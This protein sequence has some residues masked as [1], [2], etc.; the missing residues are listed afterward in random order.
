MRKRILRLGVVPAVLL[1]LIAPPSVLSQSGSRS[2][3]LARIDDS[4]EAT[5][6]R[7]HVIGMSIG[8]KKNGEVIVAKG[9]GYA[10]LENDV[11][12]TEHTVYRIGSITK[13]F[14]AA[15]IMKLVEAGMLSLDD[16]LT[17][18][19]P[20]YSTAGH[21]IT[22]DRLLNHTSGIKGYT[23]MEA[24]GE[25]M[26]EDLSQEELIALF[27]A[28][29]FEFA[30]GEKYQYNN[31]AYYLLG[32]IIEKVTGQ[33]Y[34]EYLHENIWE[35]LGMLESHYLDNSPIVRNRAEGYEFRRGR[36]VNDDPLSM[37][38]PYS[39]GSLGSSVSDL[40][41]WQAA[42]QGNRVISEG[43]YER[44]I[45]PG[46]L[47]GGKKLTYGYG[48]GI[49]AMEGHRKISHGGGING[50]RTH[51]SYYPDDDLTVVVLTNTGSASPAV[52]ESEIARAV[53]GIAR[54]D[55][56]EIDLTIA[57]LEMYAGTY[58]PGRSPIRVSVRD[59]HLMMMGVALRPIGDHRFVSS[60]DPYR[61][62][63]FTMEG[64]RA[65]RVRI[66]REGQVTEAPRVPPGP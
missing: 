44:M 46:T 33:T 57:Q 58:D 8:V 1:G 34:E 61:R 7:D 37:R 3:L 63:T 22:I 40:F 45:T 30:P 48:L 15:S 36:V 10:D 6:E 29:P 51:L 49:G 9:Y 16:E 25:V 14:T 65:G 2:E 26:R 53:L 55:I 41:T 38:L 66:E 39:A 24:F 56:P 19:L 18:F 4:V 17:A 50:F 20:D 5:M 64:D 13:Q 35:P 27:S 32:V 23:E 62:A 31:S 42:L 21:N 59:G 52:L 28:E 12:A 11:R 60:I 54:I 47:N 43:S